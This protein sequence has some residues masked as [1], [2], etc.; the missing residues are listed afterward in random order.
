MKKILEMKK[1]AFLKKIKNYVAKKVE[2]RPPKESPTK[3]Y[4]TPHALT[5]IKIKFVFAKTYEIALKPNELL[6]FKKNLGRVTKARQTDSD[7]SKTYYFGFF[8]PL[9]QELT[10][11]GIYAGR[12]TG[13][14]LEALETYLKGVKGD[15]VIIEIIYG[16]D[17]NTAD[18]AA[19]AEGEGS[20]YSR[21]VIGSS[22][23]LLESSESIA[24]FSEAEIF[25]P[26]LES[27]AEVPE[28]SVPQAE[29]SQS[30]REDLDAARAIAE[31]QEKKLEEQERII[32]ELE[33]KVGVYEKLATQG[34]LE[35]KEGGKK[36]GEQEI[37][38]RELQAKIELYEKLARQSSLETGQ[39]KKRLEEQEAVIKDFSNKIG[40][41]EKLVRQSG[42][43]IQQCRK[44]I[45]EQEFI[46]KDFQ[47]KIIN[48]EK[49]ARQ[50]DLKIRRSKTKR[51]TSKAQLQENKTLLE[52]QGLE[53]EKI[54]KTAEEKEFT[55]AHSNLEIRNLKEGLNNV[56]AENLNLKAENSR[57]KTETS[58]LK[59][60]QSDLKAE[61]S[62]LKVENSGLKA[63][64]P[65]RTEETKR[66]KGWVQPVRGRRIEEVTYTEEDRK[67]LQDLIDAAYDDPELDG[68]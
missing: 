31:E 51:Q 62:R 13:E 49:L 34:G 41:Y 55:I 60:K 17:I 10:D 61:N 63:I 35:I 26:R 6:Y 1:D 46:I 3:L 32:R 8:A 50:S 54:R 66:N 56:K 30:L 39:D 59:A 37:A 14:K 25:D 57:L 22:E 43:E 16:V 29:L 18:A 24:E 68:F 64:R 47:D 67:A 65:A 44:G 40:L 27:M 36:L 45:E 20:S 53:I 48:Y 38:I 9:M 42:L 28:P 21:S 15:K 2:G 33:G 19:K 5:L 11:A 4:T 7:A 52:V 12:N 23:S 58:S